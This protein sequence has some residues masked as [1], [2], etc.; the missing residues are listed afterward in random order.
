MIKKVIKFITSV[1]VIMLCICLTNV[2]AEEVAVSDVK[3]AWDAIKNNED[4]IESYFKEYC[5]KNEK[6]SEYLSRCRV[7]SS[8]L[9]AEYTTEALE[10]LK[11]N[12]VKVDGK[13]V[14][15]LE[16]LL[17]SIGSGDNITRD[18][19]NL[20]LVDTIVNHYADVFTTGENS[21]SELVTKEQFEKLLGEMTD[22]SEDQK[23]KY[24]ESFAQVYYVQQAWSQDKN[25]KLIEKLMKD[26][27]DAQLENGQKSKVLKDSY[28]Y[29]LI[30]TNNLSMSKAKKYSELESTA[31]IDTMGDFDASYT[32]FF[33]LANLSSSQVEEYLGN[34]NKLWNLRNDAIGRWNELY[35]G[36]V[37]FSYASWYDDDDH[38]ITADTKWFLPLE[39]DRDG[40]DFIDSITTNEVIKVDER[41]EYN[42]YHK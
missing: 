42:R 21:S 39:L 8:T 33:A 3:W 27:E 2:N 12:L 37:S 32:Y 18:I 14:L 6:I 29:E 1:F 11:A 15:T 35:S 25:K 4:S 36:N 23:N 5:E 9:A 41:N 20:I 24:R 28:V 17:K 38:T 31:N 34:Y 30:Y 26:S 7:S 13:S 40:I 10:M 19:K 16:N 22:V